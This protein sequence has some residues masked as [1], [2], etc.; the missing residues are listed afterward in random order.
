[1]VGKGPW[2][3]LLVTRQLPRCCGDGLAVPPARPW[4]MLWQ[5]PG[6]ARVFLS[7]SLV[8]EGTRNIS[9]KGRRRGRQGLIL[10]RLTRQHRG[11]GRRSPESPERGSA[12]PAARV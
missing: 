3:E 9:R 2:A 4:Q 6:I 10:H 5:M 12:A 8:S 11:S 7:L 1:M